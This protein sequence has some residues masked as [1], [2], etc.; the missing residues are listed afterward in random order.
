MVDGVKAALQIRIHNSGVSGFEHRI[1][2]HVAEIMAVNWP[3]GT[4]PPLWDG[5][6]ADRAVECLKRRIEA[7]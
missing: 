4:C 1:H 5:K 2:E 6:T 7:R 3:T